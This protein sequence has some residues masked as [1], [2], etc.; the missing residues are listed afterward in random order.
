MNKIALFVG[1]AIM[2]AMG[3]IGKQESFIAVGLGLMWM[4]IA[5]V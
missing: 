5:S 3:F 1:A 2:I 4:G